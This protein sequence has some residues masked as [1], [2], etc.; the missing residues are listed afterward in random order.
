LVLKNMT[1]GRDYRD[2]P[3]WLFCRQLLDFWPCMHLMEVR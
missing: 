1:W 3:S 2:R